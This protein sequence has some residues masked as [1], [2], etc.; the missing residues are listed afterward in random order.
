MKILDKLRTRAAERLAEL[1]GQMG[2]A[3]KNVKPA[4]NANKDTL[5]KAPIKKLAVL[6]LD[7]DLYGSTM[8]ALKPLYPNV[9]SG[10]FIIVDDYTYIPLRTGD[11]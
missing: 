6:R 3:N 2:D 9:A 1:E 5:A 8:D 4:T 7:G 11:Q 10:G